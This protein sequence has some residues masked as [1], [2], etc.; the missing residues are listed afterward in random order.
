[1]VKGRCRV[2]RFTPKPTDVIPGRAWREPC[3]GKGTH[4][5]KMRTRALP[6]G[7]PSLAAHTRLAGNDNEVGCARASSLHLPGG[8][9]GAVFQHDALGQK[10]VADAI[11][12]F[13]VLRFARLHCELRSRAAISSLSSEEISMQIRQPQFR[14]FRTVRFSDFRPSRNLSKTPDCYRETFSAAPKSPFPKIEALCQ[15][16]H[17]CNQRWRV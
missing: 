7:F 10:L 16:V 2:H 13:E 12:F 5:S 14:F 1:M 8:A 3:E 4:M 11:G 15:L 17:F 6:D 9:G